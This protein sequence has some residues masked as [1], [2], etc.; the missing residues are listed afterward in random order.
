M[1]Q[2]AVT[3]EVA[4]S[5]TGLI[6]NQG[7]F[8]VLPN[9]SILRVESSAIPFLRFHNPSNAIISVV[10]VS[11]WH[12]KSQLFILCLL[13]SLESESLQ[14]LF[15]SEPTPSITQLIQCGSLQATLL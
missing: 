15:R 10:K 11:L 2:Y 13:T 8:S 12:S 9:M 5:A 3:L 6:L 14:R 7:K 1:I 4:A